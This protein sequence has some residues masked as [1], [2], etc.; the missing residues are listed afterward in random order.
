[1]T[2]DR[3]LLAMYMTAGR[4]FSWF[5]ESR[6]FCILTDHEPLAAAFKPPMNN[7]R[8]DKVDACPLLPSILQMYRSSKALS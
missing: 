6:D 1:M 5:L 7:P 3:E 2:F 4:Y 8:V